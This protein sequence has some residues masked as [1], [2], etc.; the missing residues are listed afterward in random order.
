VEVTIGDEPL[1]V[2]EVCAVGCGASVA[3]EQ[4][5]RDRIAASRAV[6]DA[7]LAGGRAIYG[8]N[9]GVGHEKDTRLGADELRQAQEMLLITHAGGF[10]PAAGSELVR[11]AMVVRLNGLARGGSG[12]SPAVAEVLLEMLNAGVHPVVPAEGSVGSGDL[13]QLASVGLVAIGRGRA[14]LAGELL[15]GAEALRRAGI[16]PLVLAAKDGLALMSSNALSIGHAA[17]VVDRAAGLSRLAD[18][19]AVMSLE[20]TGGNAEAMLP[21][22]GTAKPYPGQVEACRGLTEML[23]DSPLLEPGPGRSVQDPLSFRVVPQVHGAY[24]DA[25]T[26]ARQAIEIEL[27]AMSDNPLVS[28]ADQSIV[29]NGNFAPI[30][31][32]LGIDAVRPA[33]AHVGQLSERRMSHL[34]D[35]FFRQLAGSGGPPPGG[36][37]PPQ[38]AGLALRYPAAEVMAGLRQLAGPATLDVPPL[39]TGGIEDHATA[40]PLAVRTTGRALDQLE[41]ILVVELLLARDVI[42]VS[43][44]APRLGAASRETIAAV[45]TVADTPSDAYEAAL[46]RIRRHIR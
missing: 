27:N 36:D 34:W 7:V 25:V 35:A 32:A 23:R 19:A 41:R 12:A 4:S 44:P 10:G 18:L 38:F 16:K 6:V 11:A 28:V 5:S 31:M 42:S 8:V 26:A 30:V 9:T 39:E 13:S 29:H 14:E 24:R 17:L 21:V 46:T 40:A 15:D 3:L 1:T 45:R 33:T 2:D 43:R 22:V 37:A 20:A